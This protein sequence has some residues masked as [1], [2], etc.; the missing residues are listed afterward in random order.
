MTNEDEVATD[1]FEFLTRFYDKHPELNERALYVCGE[2]FAGHYVP[3]IAKRLFFA[4]D[5]AI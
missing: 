2:S 4:E 3:A 5:P 1:F